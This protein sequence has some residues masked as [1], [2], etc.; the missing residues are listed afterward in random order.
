[1][2]L[3]VVLSELDQ[4]EN[5]K[6]I[7]KTRKRSWWVRDVNRRRQKQSD[8]VNLVHEL[9]NDDEQFFVYFR[10]NRR[11][12]D[13]LLHLVGPSLRRQETHMRRSVSPG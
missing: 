13:L 4:E 7:R 2:L 12:F 3:A 5:K 1:M 8:F 10:M 6:K 11:T 9:R